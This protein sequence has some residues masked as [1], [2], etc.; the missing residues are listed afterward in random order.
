MKGVKNT[1]Q[2]MNKK[3]QLGGITELAKGLA[4]VSIVFVVAVLILSNVKNNGNVVAS[5]NATAVVNTLFH[6]T[7][8]LAGWIPLIIIVAVGAV[9][10]GMLYMF[11]GGQRR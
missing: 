10:L 1:M 7:E 11:G 8:Q 2:K 9:L 6:E 3:G 5:T 4:V